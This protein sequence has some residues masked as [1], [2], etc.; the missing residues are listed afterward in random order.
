MI[1]SP[2]TPIQEKL[3]SSR[4]RI[5]QPMWLEVRPTRLVHAMHEAV[6]SVDLVFHAAGTNAMYTRNPL[7]RHFRDIHV[8]VQHNSASRAQYESAQWH[9]PP[10][11]PSAV[12]GIR[13]ARA[14]PRIIAAAATE[15][16]YTLSNPQL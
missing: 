14:K 5:E 6:R 13:S 9:F 2:S 4:A 11:R 7:E 8:A 12:S 10:L 16:R 1:L 3:L 15:T